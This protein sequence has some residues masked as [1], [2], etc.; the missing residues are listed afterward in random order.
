VERNGQETGYYE[1]AVKNNQAELMKN[2]LLKLLVVFLSL[3]ILVL[4]FFLSPLKETLF[5]SKHSPTISL[6]VVEKAGPEADS[7]LY[8]IVVEALVEGNPKPFVQFNRN[9]GVGELKSNLTLVMLAAEESFILTAVATNSLGSASS[10][11]ELSADILVGTYSR[12]D[13]PGQQ[14]DDLVAR[15]GDDRGAL[16]ANQ[17]PVIHGI[18][19]SDS[20]F[21]P[22]EVYTITAQATDPDEDA[23][24]FYWQITSEGR[25]L[26]ESTI[27]P[28]IWTAPSNTGD[29]DLNVVVSD[30]RGGE[31]EYSETI[32]VSP[33]F[34]LAALQRESGKI[35][36]SHGFGFIAGPVYT[37]D[38]DNWGV[39]PPNVLCRGFISFDI[40]QLPPG[41]IYKAELRLAEP[42]IYGDPSFMHLRTGLLIELLQS[43]SRPS[44]YSYDATAVRISDHDNYDIVLT[45]IMNGNAPRLAEELQKVLDYEFEIAQF[46]LR[47]SNQHSNN[48]AVRDGVS[49]E[50]ENITLIIWYE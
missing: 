38:T 4:V 32:S 25:L 50:R 7:G 10:S 21:Y 30:S 2:R 26:S 6:M 1:A 40:G 12:G 31:D 20:R 19:Y 49:Y 3:V 36:K 28:F 29:Y 15:E 22:G 23:L 8:R 24:S 35:V 48:D 14:S 45:S 47:F 27:N 17:P 39:P 43:D 16:T 11:I 13:R 9:E 46:R 37:G 44:S 42:A 34:R 41:K 18:D 5:P 33:F